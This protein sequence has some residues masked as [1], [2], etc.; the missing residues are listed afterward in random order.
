MLKNILSTISTRVLVALLTLIMVLVNQ[1]YLGSD[2]VGTIALIILA[3]AILQL[4]SN[5]IGGGALVYLVPRAQLM[6]IYLPSCGWAAL[7][8]ALGTFILNIL[9]LIPSGYAIH[10]FF[11]A[12]LLSLI[13][14]NFMV[15][16]GEER[17]RSYNL[18]SLLQMA[19]LFAV[20]MFFFFGLKK[21]EVMA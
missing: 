6:K 13:T 1:Y 8:S 7:T 17:I 4:V 11:L 5:L 19:I 18:I 10:V 16:M 21:M 15:L 9:H 3:I 20:L 14:T 2:K 12:L